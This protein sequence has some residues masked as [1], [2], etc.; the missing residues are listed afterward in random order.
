MRRQTGV[1]GGVETEAKTERKDW[2]T[3]RGDAGRGGTHPVD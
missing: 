3:P 2:K 1:A